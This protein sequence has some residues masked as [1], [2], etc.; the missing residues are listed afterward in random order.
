MNKLRNK[1]D[2]LLLTAFIAFVGN[3]VFD[4]GNETLETIFYVYVAYT[5]LQIIIGGLNDKRRDLERDHE[6]SVRREG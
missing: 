5:Y 3:K 2:L 1:M 6:D 4:T